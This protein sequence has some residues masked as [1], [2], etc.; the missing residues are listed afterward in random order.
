[1]TKT[2]PSWSVVKT[3]NNWFW[4]HMHTIKITNQL[5]PDH[6]VPVGLHSLAFTTN[7]IHLD[8]LHTLCLCNTDNIPSYSATSLTY[9]WLSPSHQPD[10]LRPTPEKL[11]RQ[12]LRTDMERRKQWDLNRRLLEHDEKEKA[13]GCILTSAG[14]ELESDVIEFL[15]GIPQSQDEA[16][17]NT[18]IGCS[19]ILRQ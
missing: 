16:D 6:T 18:G 1:M 7:H 14:H 13:D 17:G 3:G 11:R 15:L 5:Y 10:L 4:N 9:Q 8:F 12:N 2:F 19:W